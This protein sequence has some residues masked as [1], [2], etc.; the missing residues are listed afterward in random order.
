MDVVKSR[1]K[2]HISSTLAAWKECDF[3]C[4]PVFSVGEFLLQS[5][6]RKQ[7]CRYFPE[8]I[9]GMTQTV[10]LKTGKSFPPRKFTDWSESW[11]LCT[12]SNEIGSRDALASTQILLA[13][14]C[15]PEQTQRLNF[16]RMFVVPI[17]KT[18]LKIWTG[19][20][21]KRLR[22][23]STFSQQSCCRQLWP[24]DVFESMLESSGSCW[25]N[26]SQCGHKNSHA[27][28]EDTKH[29]NKFS[30]FKCLSIKLLSCTC[31]PSKERLHRKLW[32]ER[33][34]RDARQ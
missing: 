34:W 7:N 15:S 13:K 1:N 23:G 9:V 33:P 12:R 17:R 18:V 14:P 26:E 3:G 19:Q 29:H 6:R 2:N 30:A 10:S 25:Q 22:N 28:A 31:L 32:P 4:L 24:V 5:I 27:C 21:R 16:W 20:R 11:G 8:S